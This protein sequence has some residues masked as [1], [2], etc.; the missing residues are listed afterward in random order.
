VAMCMEG[1]VKRGWRARWVNDRSAWGDH[2]LLTSR[3][4]RITFHI[5]GGGGCGIA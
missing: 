3:H 4:R 1:H 2:I 5:A